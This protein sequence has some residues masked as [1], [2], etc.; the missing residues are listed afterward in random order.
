MANYIEW[1]NNM[2][3]VAEILA[4]SSY[5]GNVATNLIDENPNTYWLSEA[6]GP[7]NI[8]I[9]LASSKRFTSYEMTAAMSGD[10]KGP[11]R[12]LLQGSDNESEWA[13]L[14]AISNQSA[15]SAGEKRVFTFENSSTFLYYR[16]NEIY[17]PNNNWIPLSEVN[18]LE[19][20]KKTL[21]T[22][23][24]K[25]YGMTDLSVIPESA[26]SQLSDN[27]KILV[28]TKDTS[29]NSASANVTAVPKRMLVMQESDMIFE[30]PMKSFTLSGTV[31]NSSVLKVIASTD[32]GVTWKAFDGSV[33]N[34]VDKNNLD[35]VQAKGM[36]IATFNG[37]SQ[38]VWKPF[39]SGMKM[40]LAYYL[41]L[42][43]ATD[44]LVLDNLTYETVPV[45]AK[46][47]K[48]NG[49]KI[50]SDSLTIEGR[51]KDLERLNTINIAKLNFKSNALLQSE[52]YELHDMVIDTCDTDEMITVSSGGAGELNQEFSFSNPVSLGAG[53]LSELSLAS[54]ANI[55]KVEVK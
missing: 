51:L 40:R 41:D 6:P 24:F 28:L 46:S 33:W 52:K 49:I 38:E 43:A 25:N 42:A 1:R 27:F 3:D 4:S 32:S 21:T 12:W 34:T 48:L 16:L 15:W 18:L 39:L 44:L 8:K 54:F 20:V 5:G 35:D 53:K 47:P 37:I 14:H 26:W 50:E 17:S 30:K 55:K 45:V 22:D 29:I 36:N 23:D 31:Q 2:K 10:V 19:P 7:Q 11:E 13:D 9:K